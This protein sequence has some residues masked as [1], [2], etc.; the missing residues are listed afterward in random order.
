MRLNK[1]SDHSQA[2]KIINKV[3][4]DQNLVRKKAFNKFMHTQDIAI[5]RYLELARNTEASKTHL[6][7]ESLDMY[8]SSFKKLKQ[9]TKSGKLHNDLYKNGLMYTQKG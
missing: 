1:M 6:L 5:K 7:V 8:M 9:S 3:I 4:N 2:E